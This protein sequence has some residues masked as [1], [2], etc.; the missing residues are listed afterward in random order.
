VTMAVVKSPAPQPVSVILLLLNRDEFMIVDDWHVMGMQGTGS[1]SVVAKDLFVPS[2]RTARTKG[3]GLIGNVALP[4]PRIYENPMYFGR[5]PPFLIG[6]A[7]SV[8]V[9]AARGALDLFEEVL[10]QKKAPQPPYTARTADPEFR[11]HYGEALTQVVTAEAAL[12][13]AGEEFM[14]FTRDEA[15]GGPAFDLEREHRLSLI[16]I[17]CINLAWEAIDRI[18]RTAGTSASVKEGQPIGRFFRNVAAIRTH[19]ILQ[20]ERM[21]MNAARTRFGVEPPA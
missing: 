20:L 16:A 2:H 8:A 13:H 12:V 1:K 3:H 21:A 11:L 4:G 15:N 14:A 5:L 19:P 18:Y 9:G 6:E 17:N 7:A 10:L